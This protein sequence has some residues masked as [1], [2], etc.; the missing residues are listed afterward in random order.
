MRDQA[1]HWPDPD[2]AERDG[3]WPAV[4]TPYNRRAPVRWS[5]G[6]KEAVGTAFGARSRVWFT[7]ARGVVTECFYPSVDRANL[8][9]LAIIVVDDG[10]VYVDGEGDARAQMTPRAPWEPAL[11]TTALG[12]SGLTL[13]KRVLCDPERSVVLQHTRLDGPPAIAARARCFVLIEPHLDNDG[14]GNDVWLG[15]YKGARGVFAQRH[16]VAL[17]LLATPTFVDGTCAYVGD[18]DAIA[19][20]HAHGT[21][22]TRRASARDANVQAVAEL[23]LA[24]SGEATL[25]LAFG[26]SADHAAQQARAALTTPIDEQIRMYRGG[27]R[28][29]HESVTAPGPVTTRTARVHAVSV[30]V[31]RVH[32][33]KE[34]AGGIAA[35]LAIPWGEAHG[36]RSAGGYHLVW[37]R[38]LVEAASARVALGLDRSARRTLRY[39]MSAQDANGGWPQNMWLDGTPHSRG[40]QLDEV[41]LPILLAC[42]LER[43]GALDKLDAW[44]MVR[45]AALFLLREGPATPEDRWEE[46]GGYSPYTLATEVAA[47]A[48]AARFAAR[49]GEPAFAA[50]LL[51]AA[52]SWNA[53]IEAWTYVRRTPLADRYGVDGYYVRLTPAT[54]VA[55]EQIA[56]PNAR[57][58]IPNHDSVS[59]SCPYRDVVSPDALALVRFGLR[60][61][62]DPRVAATVRV[63]DGE[64][65]RRTRRGPTWRRYS[66]DGYGEGD[67]GRPHLGTGVGRGWP[68]LTGE[69]A[70]YE[71][72]AG[73]PRHAAR[74]R[75]A[76][77]R[78]ASETYLLPEQIWDADDIPARGLY[79]GRPSGSAMPLVWAHAEFLKLSRSLRDGRVFDQPAEAFVRYVAR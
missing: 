6:G 1:G 65:R 39:L 57:L 9:R 55:G 18:D 45:A 53:C 23:P 34:R 58:M 40:V 47:L 35:S 32:E 28:W 30:A 62:D 17:A 70:H 79:N 25:A 20:L 73:H 29:Y 68:L 60:A 27:W 16:G 26:E 31:L 63:I 43:E 24:P 61:A 41:A 4:A 74:L 5:P 77:A 13:V 11:A 50:E 52:D 75:H 69:R 72:A 48:G 21:L 14:D 42:L 56:D 12:T 22:T 15:E 37:P 78:Q 38:D 49:A 64:L 33:D 71:L 54:A 59:Y 51:E 3:T 46:S 76:M 7:M 44:P 66:G 2:D 10:V 36:D 8:R 19:D 67:D